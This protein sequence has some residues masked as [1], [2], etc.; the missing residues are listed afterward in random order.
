M[1]L[2]LLLLLLLLSTLFVLP[3]LVQSNS[4]SDSHSQPARI[5][6]G[7]VRQPLTGPSNASPVAIVA[8]F[9]RGHGRD[10]VT[11]GS[12]VSVAEK[13]GALHG[14]TQ[15]KMEQRVS[16]LWIYD[17]YLK[18]A[19]TD[20]GQLINLIEKTVPVAGGLRAAAIDE[21]QA[22]R[23]ALQ[24]VHPK[25]NVSLRQIRREGADTAVFASTLNPR[26]GEWPF[27]FPTALW[28]RAF[29]CRPGLKLQICCTRHW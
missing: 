12:I 3:T 29:S 9:L 17:T 24:R 27:H 8:Q 4:Q 23:A 14:I 6:R 19:L 1:K 21:Q 11:V 25:L 26:S 22:L 16:G 15:A 18:A 2:R 20:R 5:F 28:L 7:S 13:K 10:G